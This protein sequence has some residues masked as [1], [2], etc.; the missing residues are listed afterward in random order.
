MKSCKG[1]MTGWAIKPISTASC[2]RYDLLQ[3]RRLELI[4]LLWQR[5][6]GRGCTS[7]LPR[8][9]HAALNILQFEG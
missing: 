3:R 7:S 8:S 1:V 9:A 2:G 5:G 4:I 6:R